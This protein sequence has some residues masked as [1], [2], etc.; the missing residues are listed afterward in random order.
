MMEQRKLI[1]AGKKRGKYRKAQ[2]YSAEWE[3]FML[4]CDPAWHEYKGKIKQDDD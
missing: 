3:E 1:D 2:I 4:G